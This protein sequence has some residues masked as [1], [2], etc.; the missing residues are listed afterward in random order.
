MNPGIIIQG[1]ANYYEVD[2]DELCHSASRR[3]E[4]IKAKHIAMYS[5]K[6][7]TRLSL[8]A[9]GR[10]FN[11]DHATVLHAIR[12][13]EDQ[14]TVYPDYKNELLNLL[15][16]FNGATEIRIDYETDNV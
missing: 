15:R 14:M 3:K 16:K 10:L 7:L 12:S 8:G 4:L 13:V 11:R 1:T 2:I 5:C 9:V 6:K